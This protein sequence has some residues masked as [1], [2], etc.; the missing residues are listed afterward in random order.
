MEG[1]MSLVRRGIG[2]FGTICIR[3]RKISDQPTPSEATDGRG[4]AHLCEGFR[5]ESW[6]IL[7]SSEQLLGEGTELAVSIVSS[8]DGSKRWSASEET[9]RFRRASPK[10]CVLL[11]RVDLVRQEEASSFASRFHLNNAQINFPSSGLPH[12]NIFD[13]DLVEDESLACSFR[14]TWKA[15]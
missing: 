2:Y 6:M 9:L 7:L 8:F 11:L 5:S 12:E 1:E 14:R 3:E 13:K 10:Q 4:E 15:C